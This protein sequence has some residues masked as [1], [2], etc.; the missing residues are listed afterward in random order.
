MWRDLVPLI[1]IT[2]IFVR[3]RLRRPPA[4]PASDARQSPASDAH[5]RHG[6]ARKQ[7]AMPRIGILGPLNTARHGRIYR[8]A[9]K[10]HRPAA[11]AVLRRFGFGGAAASWCVKWANR[12]EAS[13]VAPPKLRFL[14]FPF[15]AVN[16]HPSR[17][18]PARVGTT[19]S[20]VDK[21]LRKCVENLRV[22]RS[23]FSQI[24]SSCR[25]DVGLN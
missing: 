5:H 24:R 8:T 16:H 18:G 20:V 7:W 14:H 2:A 22:F 21:P 19:R 4:T 6:P 12:H 3:L 9:A 15:R 17:G 25:S 13:R 11:A 23:I 10:H 1:E